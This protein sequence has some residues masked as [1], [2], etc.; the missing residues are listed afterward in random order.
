[1][2]NDEIPDISRVKYCTLKL[3]LYIQ[4]VDI[5]TFKFEFIIKN[6]KRVWTVIILP[7]KWKSYESFID[8]SWNLLLM[9]TPSIIFFILTEEIPL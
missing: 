6:R 2:M 8:M 3:K 4:T 5:Y 7:N 1:M 9:L